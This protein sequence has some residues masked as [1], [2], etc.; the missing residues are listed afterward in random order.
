[1]AVPRSFSHQRNAGMS[2]LLPCRRPAWQA[3]V[4][5]DQSVSQRTQRWLPSRSQRASV[6]ALPSRMARRRTSCA[7]PSISRKITPGTSVSVRS[8]RRRACLRTMLRY[9]DSSSSM[10]RS[11]ASSVVSSAMPSATATPVQT[12]LISAPGTRSIAKNTS[13][14]LST[15]VARPSVSTLSGR[16]RRASSGHT[17]A[18]RTPT[19]ATAASPAPGRS[20]SKPG[21]TADSTRSA[22]ASASRTTTARSRR[23]GVTG[24]VQPLDLDQLEPERLELFQE[25][26]QLGLIAD[27]SAQGGLGRLHRGCEVLEDTCHGV[28]Q[29][30]LHP[31]LVAGGGHVAQNRALRGD[32]ESPRG[33]DVRGSSRR[34]RWLRP[35]TVDA[36]MPL[37]AISVLAWVMI[38]LPI[39]LVAGTGIAYLL[40]RR[41]TPEDIE[42]AQQASGS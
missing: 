20:S 10:A 12:S 9:H 1:M 37:V 8:P 7:R 30:A 34:Q 22:S 14:P 25:P 6:G 23:A 27:L 38:G 41:R 29:P 18:F 28:A 2:S 3:P 16:A 19:A 21:S 36:V 35:M 5:D 39:L 4:C 13:I 42:R 40:G 15:S 24:L 26:G 32:G 33:G 17:T 31:D 11:E